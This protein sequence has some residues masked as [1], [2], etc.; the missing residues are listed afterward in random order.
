MSTNEASTI[1]AAILTSNEQGIP[2]SVW[3]AVK[4][5][6]CSSPKHVWEAWAESRSKT[7]PKELYLEQQIGKLMDYG[8][9][10]N[11]DAVSATFALIY[12]MLGAPLPEGNNGLMWHRGEHPVQQ[13]M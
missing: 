13:A 7:M 8:R 1:I 2:E 5:A 3:P 4:A 12:G 9:N 10:W 6:G 11:W